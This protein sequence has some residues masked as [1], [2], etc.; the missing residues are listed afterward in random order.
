[1]T[2]I[3]DQQQ[4]HRPDVIT[5]CRFENQVLTL[6]CGIPLKVDKENQRKTITTLYSDIKDLKLKHSTK[7]Q[8]LIAELNKVCLNVLWYLMLKIILS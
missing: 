3:G 6:G 5:D 8:Q 4:N 2:K 1:M 7:E